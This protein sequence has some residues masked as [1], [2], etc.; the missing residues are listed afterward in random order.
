ME[1]GGWLNEVE[2]TDHQPPTTT[3]TTTTPLPLLP[4]PPHHHHHYHHYT[5][6]PRKPAS[7]NLRLN[8]FAIHCTVESIWNEE[9]QALERKLEYIMALM[10][11]HLSI[12]ELSDELEKR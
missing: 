10:K 4:P 8:S 11:C 3:T 6:Q 9:V 2:S 12:F 7:D 1:D 5:I